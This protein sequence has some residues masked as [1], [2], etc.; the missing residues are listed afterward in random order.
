MNNDKQK[1][2]IFR[3]NKIGNKTF[4]L[5]LIF[6]LVTTNIITFFAFQK[7]EQTIIDDITH[8]Y[9]LI[10]ISR[11]LIEQEHFINTLQ[12][13]RDYFKDLVEVEGKDSIAIYFEYLNTGANISI[14][15][16]LRIYPASLVK[17]PLA[18]AVMKKVEDG[19]WR[20]Q[21]EMVVTA[22]DRDYAWG[23]VHKNPI[24]TTLTIEKLLE[25]MLISS[26]NTAYR[27]LYRN[28]NIDE[29]QNVLISLGIE[30]LF[31]EEGKIGAKEYS[32]I[33]RALYVSSYLNRESSQIILDILTRSS[34][35]EYLGQG[36]PVEVLFAHK[37]GENEDQGVVLDS[38]IVYVENRPYLMTVM[39]D[40]KINNKGRDWALQ[41][42]KQ[43]SDKAYS[44]I[45][46]QQ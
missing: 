45:S 23:D 7:N 34:Y 21:N 4:F 16:Q 8:K 39:I 28:L 37:I 10:D 40:Y 31:S 20:L 27:I 9:P 13:L 38:G 29:L 14:N 19:E 17:V 33:F 15:D 35:D 46:S 24:G 5:F 22:E 25:E 2:N 1:N 36:V 18:M 41:I 43:I 30:D 3:P 12:P 11:S 6:I 32:R 42:M 44:Y 26:D